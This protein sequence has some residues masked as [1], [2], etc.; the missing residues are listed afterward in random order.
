MDWNGTPTVRP[1]FSRKSTRG[2]EHAVLRELNIANGSVRD[3]MVDADSPFS[4]AFSARGGR[5]AYVVNS[6]GH[7]NIWRGDLLHPDAPPVKFISTT[8]DQFCPRYSPDGK[9]IAFAS[10]R[11]GAPEIWMSDADGQDI[12][13]FTNL[14][15]LAAGSLTWSPDSRNIAFDSRAKTPEG[16]IRPDVYIVDITER[17]PK[18][19]N[20]GTPGAFQPS[21]SHD[22]KW[23]YFLGG[24]DDAAG[25][26]IYRVPR[27]GGKP[28]VVT[29]ARGFW[30]LESLDG[31]TLYFAENSGTSFTLHMASLYPTGT[32]IKIEGMPT[33][34]FLLNWEVVPDGVHFFPMDDHLTVSYF[35]FSTK[36]VHRVFKVGG[37]AF[38]GMSVSLD[39]RYILYPEFDDYQSDIMLVENFQ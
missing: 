9:H 10:N 19:L 35:D 3:R 1:C 27:E 28:E 20:T 33:L 31:K 39:E 5:L 23:I 2:V 4:E 26:R 13:Q 8:R 29:T 22:G 7:H 15:S 32:E 36:K 6:S 18:K 11:G 38:L 12:L 34:S 30:P 16:Q 25:E 37:G 14:K 21:W 24:S 17:A